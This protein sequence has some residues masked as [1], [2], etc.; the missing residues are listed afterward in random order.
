MNKN[1]IEPKK[2]KGNRPGFRLVVRPIGGGRHERSGPCTEVQCFAVWALTGWWDLGEADPP[3]PE[4]LKFQK[5]VEAYLKAT[6]RFQKA[7]D[8]QAKGAARG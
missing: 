8:K 7:M 2:K 6:A 1:P 4:R 3:T 5:A